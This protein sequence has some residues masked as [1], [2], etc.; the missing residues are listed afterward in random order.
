MAT[1]VGKVNYNQTKVVGRGSYGT[2]VFR[3]FLGL[4]EYDR[5]VAVKRM[6][7][8]PNLDESLI[9]REVELMKRASEHPNILRY[10]RQDSD[11]IFL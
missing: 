11:P 6:Q 5:P 7:R 2:Y 4:H 3:G 1:R 9:Q 8:G 10:I